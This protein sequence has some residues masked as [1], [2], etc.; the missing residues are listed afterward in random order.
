MK[1]KLG[2]EI[3]RHVLFV[4]AIRL[5]GCDPTSGLYGICKGLPLKRFVRDTHFREHIK[6][7]DSLPACWSLQWEAWRRSCLMYCDFVAFVKRCLLVPPRFSLK[8]AAASYDSIRVYHQQL[9]QWKDEDEQIPAEERGWRL[10]DGKLVPIMTHLQPCLG[11]H[12]FESCF[13]RTLG[14][15]DYFIFTRT[16]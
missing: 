6:V 16:L 13:C 3:C 15:A 9:S 1:K 12:R 2:Q 8:A 4:H 14:H 5:S 11:G 10:H 7:F